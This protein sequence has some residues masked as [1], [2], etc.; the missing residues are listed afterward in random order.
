MPYKYPESKDWHVPKQ[1]HKITN[2]SEYN[3]ALT[4]RG[5][6]DIWLTVDAVN[7]WHE[8]DQKN[9]GEG[10]PQ[11]YTDFAIRICH[12]IRMIYKQPLRQTQGF[13]NSLFE[14]MGLDIQC[15]NFC[16]LSK[17]LKSLGIECPKY[18]EKDTVDESVA[19]ISIDSTGLKRFGR[20]E[21]HQEKHKVSAKRSWRK[22]HAAVSNKHY[23]HAVELTNRFDTDERVVDK[24]FNQIGVDTSHFSAG[25]A[26]DSFNVYEKINDK[27]PSR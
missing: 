16:T 2:G 22:Y 27:F 10:T 14:I 25:G 11:R 20:D 9:I 4:N 13:I 5:R 17:R 15:P 21:W 18:T 6:I 12:E 7:N 1:K 26:Y 3:K 23:I 19:D 24:L 8:K